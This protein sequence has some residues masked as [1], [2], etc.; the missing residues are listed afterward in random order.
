MSSPN[1]YTDPRRH[2]PLAGGINFR[3]FGGYATADGGRV[4]WGKL[5]RSG[6]LTRLT[7]ACH[8]T[9]HTLEVSAVCDFRTDAE[10]REEPSR[11]PAHLE[12]RV[13]RLNIWPK[14][15]RTMETLI[16]DLFHGR[17]TQAEMFAQQNEVYREFVVDFAAHYADMFRHILA[18][19]G[20]P[21][22][23]HCMAGKDRTGL[24]AAMI[25]MSLGVPEDAVH[26]DYLLTNHGENAIKTCRGLARRAAE[27]MGISD[28]ADLERLH[29]VCARLYH[30]RPDC[31]EA[32]LTAMRQTA[33]SVE[34]YFADALKLSPADRR[35]LKDW[36]VESA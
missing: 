32:G 34:G 17:F 36:F 18:A 9:L 21:V 13:K 15:S 30:V 19:G 3:D 2:P 24:G 33:G 11:V 10:S 31:L 22:L 5:Y 23:I 4:K 12:G 20:R 29:D 7:D 26:H 16:K 1:P 27:E 8:A 14:S 28:A 35:R 25:Q 6:L